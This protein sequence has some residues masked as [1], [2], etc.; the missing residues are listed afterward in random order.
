MR[1]LRRRFFFENSYRR[2]QGNELLRRMINTPG[3]D[4]AFWL[5]RTVL[6]KKEDDTLPESIRE[7]TAE[8]VERNLTFLGL[9]AMQDPPRAEVKEAVKLCRSAG[10]KIIMIT[11][12]YGLT[13]ESIARKIGYYTK[14]RR[15]S[16]FRKRVIENG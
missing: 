9:V 11:G 2:R 7:Y 16:Y 12:D 8:N 4:F 1:T 3:K 6:Y 15:E 10:I 13:A 14:P 5:S